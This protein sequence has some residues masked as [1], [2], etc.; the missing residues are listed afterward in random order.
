MLASIK[1]AIK[2]S[3]LVVR[4]LTCSSCF[5][6]CVE[7]KSEVSAATEGKKPVSESA[8]EPV[9][10]D[11]KPVIEENTFSS[12]P[13]LDEVHAI[14]RPTYI[15]VQQNRTQFTSDSQQHVSTAT[16]GAGGS[17]WEGVPNMANYFTFSNKR[18]A[19][20]Q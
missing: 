18:R 14:F 11:V 4:I 17:K 3:G 20:L 16:V 12:D 2:T 9:T 6:S 19:I 13:I 5:C 15:Y 7:G 10:V 1:Q 8:K